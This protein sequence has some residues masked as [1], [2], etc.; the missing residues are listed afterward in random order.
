M[1]LV[2]L[3]GFALLVK[4]ASQLNAQAMLTVNICFCFGCPIAKW[5]ALP[6]L[7]LM[8]YWNHNKRKLD[9]SQLKGAF[10]NFL[11]TTTAVTIKRSGGYGLS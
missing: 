9:E 8:S 11:L 7:N 10:V 6:F 2:L 1:M 3:D 4:V 5:F